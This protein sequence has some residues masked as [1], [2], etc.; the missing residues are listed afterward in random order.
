MNTVTL[1]DIEG[2]RWGA[3]PSEAKVAILAVHGRSQQ[4]SYVAEVLDRLPTDLPSVTALLPQAEGD[5]WYP[6]R[7]VA[8]LEENQPALDAAL[9]AMVLGLDA[10][11]ADGFPRERVVLFG[12]SQGSCLLSTLLLS[13]PAAG[14]V[15]GAALFA[16]GDVGPE[17]MAP[18]PGG[19]RLDGVPVR[20]AL[21]DTDPWAPMFRT[22]ETVRAL[23]DRGA[24]ATVDVRPGDEHDVSDGQVRLL[25]ELI[26][27]AAAR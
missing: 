23:A 10:L 16:G 21:A 12:F 4:T 13:E 25:A 19:A 8:P 26:R 17:G 24:E 14:G 20:M 22:E 15:G 1:G 2:H 6:Q 7:F 9:A 11:K 27:S 18:P 3:D 5:S